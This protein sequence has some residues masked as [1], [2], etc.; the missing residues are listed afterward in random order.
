MSYPIATMLVGA[1]IFAVGLYCKIYPSPEGPMAAKAETASPAGP[2]FNFSAPSTNQFNLPAPAQKVE[3][4]PDGI[5]QY[6]RMVGKVIA[7]RIVLNQSRAFFDQIQNAG[8]L[9]RA[10]AFEYRDH[11]LR[12]LKAESFAGMSIV[13][14]GPVANNVYSGVVCEIV[15]RTNQP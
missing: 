9:D 11:M 4:D 13:V 5:Y 10:K 2:T 12:F 15:G 3:R 8:D 7:P 6:G 14:G 1:A